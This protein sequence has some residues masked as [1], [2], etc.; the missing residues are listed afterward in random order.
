VSAD[1]PVVLDSARRHGI[2]DEDMLH[3]FRNPVRTFLVGTDLTMV[4]GADS[5]GRLLE[6]GVVESRDEPGLVIVHAMPARSKFLV[7]RV[8]RSLEEII[9]HADELADAFERYDPSPEDDGKASSLV[10]LRVAAARRAEAD[11]TLLEA[12]SEA[13]D[14]HV[15]W[16]TIGGL[17]GTSGEAA[18][19]RYGELVRR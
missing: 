6:V 7:K 10:T 2:D 17:L 5:S 9:E 4:I 11:R 19:Q 14:H 16:K 3:A 12:V 1:Q 8:P 13:R 18:R 15:S